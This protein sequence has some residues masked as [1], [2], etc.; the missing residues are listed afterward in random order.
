MGF[1]GLISRWRQSSLPPG[2]LK[3]EYA[4]LPTQ[5]PEATFID[6]LWPLP[7]YLKH[8]LQPLLPLSQLL[9]PT[10]IFLSPF[11]KDPCHYSG[12]IQIIR[13]ELPISR[14]LVRHTN[15]LFPCKV[16][17]PHVPGIRMW[18]SLVGHYSAHQTGMIQNFL[19]FSP[20]CLVTFLNHTYFQ[21]FQSCCC[22]YKRALLLY[23]LKFDYTVYGKAI[24]FCIIILY[25]ANLVFLLCLIVFQL[26][27]LGFS[28]LQSHQ[29]QIEL[30]L[31]LLSNFHIFNYSF[32]NVLN[33]TS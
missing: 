30:I 2:N 15:L 9:F 25:A 1:T 11:Y 3:R 31:P 21:I 6:Q 8:T 16:T 12:P 27:L 18:M 4:P 32:V 5:F 28:C 7:P 17:Q 24:D 10:V 22:C 29:L 20:K 19:L 13:N 26:F 33:N 14:T 23:I